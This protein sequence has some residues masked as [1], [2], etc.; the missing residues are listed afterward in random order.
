MPDFAQI[1]H[2]PFNPMLMGG[3]KSKEAPT[4]PTARR[5]QGHVY[6]TLKFVYLC[7]PYL[8]LTDVLH[9]AACCESILLCGFLLGGVLFECSLTEGGVLIVTPCDSLRD[10][11]SSLVELETELSRELWD[12]ESQ[13]SSMT[14]EKGTSKG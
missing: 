1:D 5:G 10:H 2:Q 14:P 6:L 8:A 7:E 3:R 9:P 11:S 12:V 4:G 13:N